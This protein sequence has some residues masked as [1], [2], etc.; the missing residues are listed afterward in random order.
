MAQWKPGDR[1]VTLFNQGHQYGEP[2]ARSFATGLG[3][4]LDGTL[5]QYAVFPET[6]LVRAPRNL[7]WEEAG[8]LSC[9]ALTAWNALYG[10]KPLKPGEWV[11]VQGTGGV[12]LFSLQVCLLGVDFLSVGVLGRSWLGYLAQKRLTTPVKF[13]KAAGAMVIATTSSAEKVEVVKKLGADFV[14][15]YKEDKDWGTTA[16]G[17]TPDGDGVDHVVE[18]GGPETLGQSV[19][20]IKLGGV[21]S[22][23]GVLTGYE[24]K[25][26]ALEALFRA[27][28]LRGVMVGSRAQFEDMVRAVEVNDLHPVISETVF[29]FGDAKDAYECQ[30]SGH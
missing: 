2:T 28:I 14:I 27:C 10:L 5:R 4:S 6:G 9:A 11:L 17:F 1:V 24:P 7:G 26:T 21:V 20:A 18:V 19:N 3:G 8:T 12:S 25:V 13:A 29:S 22:L 23:V 16:K 30:V 15:N